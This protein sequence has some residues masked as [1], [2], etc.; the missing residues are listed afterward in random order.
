VGTITSAYRRKSD[1]LVA[2][3]A[4]DSWGV[5]SLDELFECGLTESTVGRWVA[6]CI[7]SIAACTRWGTR[8]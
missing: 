7:A 1:T 5:L 2:A 8:A 4:A 3:R 6:T